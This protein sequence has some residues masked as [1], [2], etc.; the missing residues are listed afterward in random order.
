M[1]RRLGHY[2]FHVDCDGH[3][4]SEPVAG[5]IAAL[6]HHCEEVRVLGTYAAAIATMR[7]GH[8]GIHST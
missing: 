2:V 6:G 5:A 7:D 8:G 3:A 4:A 1:R